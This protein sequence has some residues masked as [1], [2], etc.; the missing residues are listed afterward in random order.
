MES[1]LFLGNIDGACGEGTW[2]N[3]VVNIKNFFLHIYIYRFLSFLS[4]IHLFY[5]IF[6]KIFWKDCL[7]FDHYR[8]HQLDHTLLLI[9][10]PDLSSFRGSHP[11]SGFL[12]SNPD[13]G[14]FTVGS[15]AGF[16]WRTDQWIGSDFGTTFYMYDI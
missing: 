9:T 13:P 16:S 6:K 14:F 15:G 2:G 8:F 12:R 4:Y 5:F 1:F 7:F 3:K 11:D 10:D